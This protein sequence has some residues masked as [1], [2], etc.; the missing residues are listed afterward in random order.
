MSFGY[1][2]Y[3]FQPIINITMG[4][5]GLESIVGQRCASLFV[6]SMVKPPCVRLCLPWHRYNLGN[7]SANKLGARPNRVSC[8]MGLIDSPDVLRL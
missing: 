2:L 5:E 3:L 6:F 1:Y 4:L 8:F 7:Y